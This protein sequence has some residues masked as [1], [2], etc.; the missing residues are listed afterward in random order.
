V[1]RAVHAIALAATA[2][3]A[4]AV[5]RA[6]ADRRAGRDASAQEDAPV[7]QA[8]FDAL[9]AEVAAA[10]IQLRLRATVVPPE[11][12]DARLTQAF[13]TRLVVSD[14]AR[15]LALAHRKQL[16]LYPSVSADAVEATRVLAA[17]AAALVAADAPDLGALAGRLADWS[18]A[19]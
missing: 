13:E 3:T 7:A 19:D 1:T 15:A 6:V 8:D 12:P 9:R 5:A 17:D 10:A 16:S 11:D 18:A 14:A 4:L 2:R